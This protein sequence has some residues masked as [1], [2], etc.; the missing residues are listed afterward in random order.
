M[1]RWRGRLTLWCNLFFKHFPFSKKYMK[2]PIPRK[3]TRG[4]F[5]WHN[6]VLKKKNLFYPQNPIPPLC[7]FLAKSVQTRKLISGICSSTHSGNTQGE[8]TILLLK[9][10][11]LDKLR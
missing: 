10:C 11:H 8:D 4:V 6:W 2:N 1:F 9:T 7:S 5:L 3:D